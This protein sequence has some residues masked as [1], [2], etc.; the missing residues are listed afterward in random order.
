MK[1]SLSN[2]CIYRN[3]I[4]L[5]MVSRCYLLY[6]LISINWLNI[7]DYFT[8]DYD[9]L[10]IDKW[11]CYLQAP[12]SAVLLLWSGPG[13]NFS[14]WASY[15]CSKLPFHNI[16]QNN[17]KTPLVPMLQYDLSSRTQRE[18][19]LENQFTSVL[20]FLIMYHTIMYGRSEN[21][22]NI[23]HQCTEPAGS[24]SLCLWLRFTPL[25]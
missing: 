12:S 6:C 25:S 5:L 3:K 1:T 18:S 4:A 22:D 21:Q 11:P 20:I 14:V 7:S 2:I 24:W 23:L 16:S 19:Q 17:L 13:K 15:S 8:G 10:H 9:T